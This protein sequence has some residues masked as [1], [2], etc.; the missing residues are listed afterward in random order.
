MTSYPSPPHY[1][2]LDGTLCQRLLRLPLPVVPGLLLLLLLLR[3]VTA[4][5]S[6][7][8]QSSITPDMSC[9]EDLRREHLIAPGKGWVIADRHTNIPGGVESCSGQRLY[10]TENNG[11]TWRDITPPQMPTHSIGEVFF[12]DTSHGWMLS[13]DALSEETNA[14]FYLLSTVDA[15]RNWRTLVLTRPM[16]KMYDDYT[17]PVQLF[18]SDPSN[19]W[20]MWRW[21]IMISRLNYLLATADGGRTWKRLPEPPGPGPFQFLSRRE[22]WMIGGP[23]NP[24]GIPIPEAENLWSTH[25]GGIHWH[26][27]PVPVPK[28]EGGEAYFSSFRFK[29]KREGLAVAELQLSGYVFRLFSCVTHDGGR[30]WQISHFDA[31]HAAPSLLGDHIIWSISDWPEMKIRIQREN[32][33][34]APALPS[35]PGISD[36]DFID[37]QN[38]WAIAGQLLTTTDGGRTFR[39]ITPPAVMDRLY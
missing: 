8:P 10:W 4:T 29:D 9:S 17:F 27:V 37:D 13:S 2:Q 24:D 33:V 34:V 7:S 23:T 19:G 32:L 12:L 38:G 30:S 36:V 6:I 1:R 16:F 5:A 15:G 18:F 35:G 11:Q 21:G 28:D 22:G 31:Y 39:V 14:K 26:V 25:D 3:L 20:M